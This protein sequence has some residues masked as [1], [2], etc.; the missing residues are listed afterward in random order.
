MKLKKINSLKSSVYKSLSI[1]LSLDGFSFC[2]L[3]FETQ[4]ILSYNQ[5]NF[6]NTIKSPEELLEKV[7][8]IFSINI[9]LQKDFKK[10]E[11][12]HQNNL[13]TLVPDTYFDENCLKDYL[14]FSIKT[15]ANDYITFDSLKNIAT[16][17]VYIPF[18]NVNNYLFQN[19]GEFEYKHHS[20]ILIEKLLS[21]STEQTQKQ[22]FVNV[23]SS[24]LDIIVTD[25]TKLILY[26]SF[27]YSTKED[28]IYYILFVAEQLR[29]DPNIFQLIFLGEIEENS[30]IYKITYNYVRNISF[31]K[32][33][34]KL[35]S[36][37]TDF[38]N[39]SNYIL[40][41]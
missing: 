22:F 28:F 29:L 14:N 19:F 11:V 9:E 23:S 32:S 40:V 24:S 30:E 8:F 38:S 33:S 4:D 6:Y 41:S 15:L 16:K 18:V 3:D 25:A 26:N 34:S 1:Q 37:S 20:T 10:V 39:H 2:V 27:S 12:I 31:I 17:N 7:K 5:Y 13:A 35:F 36:N 21:Y